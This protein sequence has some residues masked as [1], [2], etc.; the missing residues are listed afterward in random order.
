MA[1]METFFTPIT[2]HL[3]VVGDTLVARMRGGLKT[4]MNFLLVRSLAALPF[5]HKPEMAIGRRRHYLATFVKCGWTKQVKVNIVAE[6]GNYFSHVWFFWETNP[7]ILKFNIDIWKQM[8]RP[9]DYNSIRE[10]DCKAG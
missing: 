3:A 2:D 6:K 8:L 9:C 1:L 7:S 10:L 4:Y 5:L